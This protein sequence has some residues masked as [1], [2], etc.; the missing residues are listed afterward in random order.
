[1]ENFGGRLRAAVGGGAPLSLPVARCFL[2]L[3][4]ALL[5]GYGMTE[6]IVTST[7]KKIAPVDVEIAITD[8][9]LF[10]QACVVGDDRPFIS[11]IVVLDP[12]EW[13]RLASSLG[14]DPTAPS[15]LLD[16]QAVAAARQRIDAL[17][18][19]FPRHAQPRAVSLTLDPWTTE[20]S[21]L[22]TT[23]KIKRHNLDARFAAQIEAMYRR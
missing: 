15:A 21:L 11:C 10:Q 16:P 17:T 6:I 2:G 22:T 18:R 23:L 3:G 13:K 20:N 14:L 1:M 5:Q 9:P 12:I 7:G 4:P 19:G 8:D